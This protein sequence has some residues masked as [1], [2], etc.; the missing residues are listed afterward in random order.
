[1]HGIFE[2]HSI[3]QRYVYP[4]GGRGYT[5]FAR[6]FHHALILMVLILSKIFFQRMHGIFEIHSIRQRYVYA[7]GGRGFIDILLISRFKRDIPISKNGS[8]TPL[9]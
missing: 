1:M 9:F 3:Y 5:H 2:I 4:I 7:I 6:R 8:I